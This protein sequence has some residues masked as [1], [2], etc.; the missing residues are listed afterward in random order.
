MFCTAGL[1]GTAGFAGVEKIVIA[2]F[3]ALICV[4]YT[5]FC[6]VLRDMVPTNPD[7]WN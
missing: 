6:G 3:S 2:T 1:S 5:V 4:S 7:C